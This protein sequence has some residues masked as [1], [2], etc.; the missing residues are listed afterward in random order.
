MADTPKTLPQKAWHLIVTQTIP[1][2]FLIGHRL[3]PR[4]AERSGF[5]M[6]WLGDWDDFVIPAVFMAI[7]VMMGAGIAAVS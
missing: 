7:M 3:H 4:R 2:M 1:A 6:R 5:L